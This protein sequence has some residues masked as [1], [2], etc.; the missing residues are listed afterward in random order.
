MQNE[1]ETDNR[2]AVIVVSFDN[3][4]VQLRDN[5]KAVIVVSFDDFSVQPRVECLF[6]G[7]FINLLHNPIRMLYLRF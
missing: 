4:S 3:F 5:R 1:G 2:K 6:F 7:F